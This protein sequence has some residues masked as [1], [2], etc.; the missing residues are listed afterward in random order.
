MSDYDHRNQA[1]DYSPPTRGGSGSGAL[2]FIGGIIALF[3]LAIIFMGSG[4]ST[5]PEEGAAAPAVESTTPVAP[6]VT[7]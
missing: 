5:L 2:M 1:F 7:E 3:I 4:S 6:A